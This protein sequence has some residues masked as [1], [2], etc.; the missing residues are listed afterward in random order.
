MDL[1][2]WQA[3][4]REYLQIVKQWSPRTTDTYVREL[5]PLLDFLKAQGVTSMAGLTASMLEEY[6]TML[7]YARHRERSLSLSTQSV[8]FAAVKQFARFLFRESYLLLDI[9]RNL[10]SPK[11]GQ[12]L[13]RIIL[14][15]TEVLRLLDAVTLDTTMGLRDRAVIELLYGNG[16]RNSELRQLELGDVD[17]ERRTLHIHE[18]KGR[19][20][21]VVPL[22][23]E[24]E[25]WLTEYLQKARP[26]LLR[27]ASTKWVF[28][29]RRGFL[30]GRQYLAK[31]VRLYGKK[32][33]LEKVV[34]PHVLRHCCATHMLSRGAGI[35]QLQCLLGHS[36]LNTTQVYT[37]VEITDLAKVVQRC[38]PRERP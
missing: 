19:K 16:M 12:R 5:K 7:F 27:E 4:Y 10:E 31:M 26:Q 6:R 24:A 8:R 14:S 38:H 18:G 23:E 13:P 1:R 11:G 15:E 25:I 30:L 22:G 3:R 37:K 33:G 9:T 28:L 17:F 2:L 36:S 21:R 35:R 34:T 20:S 32:A 29:S